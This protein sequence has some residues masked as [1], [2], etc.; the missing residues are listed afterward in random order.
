M[1][2]F[3]Q[4]ISRTYLGVGNEGGYK[5]VRVQNKEIGAQESLR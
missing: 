4:G 1:A 5:S 2:E 3:S